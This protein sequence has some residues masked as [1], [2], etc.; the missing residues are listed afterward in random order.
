M[1]CA[2][3]ENVK[4]PKLL[5]KRFRVLYVMGIELFLPPKL[6]RSVMGKGKC[7]ANVMLVKTARC[8]RFIQEFVIPVMVIV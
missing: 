4:V 6:V 1:R 5:K 8:A 3:A 7:K 2:I